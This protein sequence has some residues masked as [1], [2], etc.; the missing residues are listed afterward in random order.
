MAL[1]KDYPD[2]DCSLARALELL[3]ERW[4]ML[5]VRDAFYGVR[6]YNDFLVHLDIPRAV[7]AE[8]L[9]ALTSAGVLEKRTYQESP[10]RDEYVLTERGRELW[11][12]LHVLS[13]W[14]ERHLGGDPKRLFVH[15]SCG[16]RLDPLG[17]CPACERSVDPT[18]IEMRPGPGA[19][20]K[21]TDRV[22][23]A[24][25]QPRRLLEPLPA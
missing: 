25:R 1:G 9:G 10:R 23:L 2:Q 15:A 18:E 22:S 13:R 21:R 12:A 5:V 11:P 7:L 8:R 19:D 17:H 6:R 4:T 20:P 14:G 3:G 16:T 24:L